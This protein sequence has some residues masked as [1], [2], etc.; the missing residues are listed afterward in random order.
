MQSLKYN[1]SIVYIIVKL[2]KVNIKGSFSL[3]RP[4]VYEHATMLK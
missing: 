4:N 1:S 3:Y 2:L